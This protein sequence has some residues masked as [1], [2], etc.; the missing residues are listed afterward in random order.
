MY[1]KNMD[2][3][4]EISLRT[5]FYSLGIIAAFWLIWDLQQL[6]FLLFFAFIITSAVMPFI[7]MLHA[8]GVPRTIAVLFTYALVILWCVLFSTV[9]IP[10]LVTQSVRLFNS[11]PDYF[12]IVSPYIKVDLNTVVGQIAPL[13]QNVVKILGG[14]FSNIFAI[15]TVF[16]FSFYFTLEHHKLPQMLESL[17]GIQRRKQ[18]IA[19]IKVIEERMGA[20]V[21]GQL[22]LMFIIG[23]ASFL[24]L[25]V[26]GINYALPLAIFAGILEAVPVIGPNVS[27][28]P[29]VLVAL[30]VSPGLAVAVIVLYFIIQQSENN[31]IVPFVMRSTVGIPPLVS[32]LTLF[33]GARLAG[34]M[35]AILA[36][37]VFLVVQTIILEIKKQRKD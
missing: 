3:R 33:I 1:T 18:V 10:P 16:V 11:L 24:G 5:V 9:V 2:T 29:A 35:G 22:I 4:V 8:T 31:L 20:W 32:L 17:V 19:I 28:I 6:I 27:A 14:I 36:I 25:T 12:A 26:M 21:R 15:F 23:L 7:K 13:G 34:V 37:P 30:S